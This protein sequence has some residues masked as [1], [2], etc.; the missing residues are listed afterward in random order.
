VKWTSKDAKELLKA[1]LWSFLATLGAAVA[2][3]LVNIALDLRLETIHLAFIAVVSGLLAGLAMTS[4][5]IRRHRRDMRLTER[6][7]AE[8]EEKLERIRRARTTV[9]S[10]VLGISSTNPRA[11]QLL[12]CLPSLRYHIIAKSKPIDS[13]TLRTIVEGL[14][15]VDQTGQV[16]PKFGF[17]VLEH[18]RDYEAFRDGKT[19]ISKYGAREV[20][21][22]QCELSYS[23]EA[24]VWIGVEARDPMV[25]VEL[26][27]RSSSAIS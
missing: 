19:F 13:D 17:Y 5:V 23:E 8:A 6:K 1:F 3:Q 2:T 22:Y 10:T 18:R 11:T 9:L 20:E 15:T 25:R 14:F 24:D 16:A 21:F 4:L 26:K 7:L 27:V 12:K